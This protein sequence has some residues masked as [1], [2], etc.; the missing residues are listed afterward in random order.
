MFSSD[1]ECAKLTICRGRAV[2]TG[3]IVVSPDVNIHGLHTGEAYKYLGYCESKGIDHST[4][5]QH[6]IT[7]YSRYLLLVW[8][9][10][11]T[12]KSY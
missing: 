2:Q 12:G 5:K 10:L 11:L 8:K 7:E 1:V 6:L 9:S 4:S 3:D